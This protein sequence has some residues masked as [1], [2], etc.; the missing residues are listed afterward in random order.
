MYLS[1]RDALSKNLDAN[2]VVLFSR[3][4]ETASKSGAKM[5]AAWVVEDNRL[6]C[7]WHPA[8]S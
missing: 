8:Q 1:A 7:K 2:N 5:T 6:V 3:S 4:F